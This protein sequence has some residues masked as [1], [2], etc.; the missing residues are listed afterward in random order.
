M[1]PS[2]RKHVVDEEGSEDA[3]KKLSSTAGEVRDQNTSSPQLSLEVQPPICLVDT[4]GDDKG[5]GNSAG[6]VDLGDTDHDHINDREHVNVDFDLPITHT[7]Q[8][9]TSD[10]QAIEIQ[11]TPQTSPSHS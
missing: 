10:Q 4:E 5:L 2:N 3:I 11:S 6:N 1:K 9:H 7:P 8:Q